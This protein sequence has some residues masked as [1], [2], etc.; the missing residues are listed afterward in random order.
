M[1][2]TISRKIQLNT[3]NN[4]HSMTLLKKYLSTPFSLADK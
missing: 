2:S 3:V 1:H 4:F